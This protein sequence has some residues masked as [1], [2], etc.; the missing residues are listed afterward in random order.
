MGVS[1]SGK[2]TVGT[3]LGEWI[4][5]V[6]LD[7]DNLHPAENIAKM[8]RGEALGDADRWPWLTTV[9]RA[10]DDPSSAVIVGCSALK[11]AY[12]DHIRQV[13]SGDVVFV[14][15]M[16]SR[17]LIGQRIAARSGHFMPVSL[18]DNQFAT[19]EPPGDDERAITV[20]ISQPINAIVAQIV[21]GLL[22]EER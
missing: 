18:L 8:S 20:D 10:L 6:Y 21:A 16:G 11:R 5:A 2:T 4:G 13:A 14:H 19:L 1:G 15:L 22:E 17:E 7:G 12:R 9:G 3:A